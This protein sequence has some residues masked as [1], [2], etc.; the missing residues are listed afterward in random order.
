VA[1]DYVRVASVAGVPLYQ[2]RVAMVSQVHRDGVLPCAGRAP[3][4]R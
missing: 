3:G 4:E 2:R 1:R